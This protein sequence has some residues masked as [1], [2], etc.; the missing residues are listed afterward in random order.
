MLNYNRMIATWNEFIQEFPD[1]TDLTE[2]DLLH[3]DSYVRKVGSKWCIFSED[4]S[5][6]GCKNSKKEAEDR[7][8]EIEMFK[9]M[10]SDTHT[11]SSRYHFCIC[12]NCGAEYAAT[13]YCGDAIC[14]ACGEYKGVDVTDL[15]EVE[16]SNKTIAKQECFCEECHSEFWV[17][18]SCDQS[19]CPVCGA[20]PDSL[21]E[22]T[23]VM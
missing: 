5:N 10:K 11:E 17:H 12:G 13:K 23:G 4:G 6:L 21:E 18:T 20:G 8:A 2:F 9:H 19:H 15:E 3:E 7:L 22:L 1:A 14:P 16:G